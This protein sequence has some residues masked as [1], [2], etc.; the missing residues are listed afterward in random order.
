[1]LRIQDDCWVIIDWFGFGLGF[2]C[3]FPFQKLLARNVGNASILLVLVDCYVPFPLFLRHSNQPFILG[4]Y[5]FRLDW[6]FTEASAEATGP[7][8]ISKLI[9]ASSPKYG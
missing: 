4:S 6:S 1:M 8:S 2:R 5:Y 9:V 3:G 7:I